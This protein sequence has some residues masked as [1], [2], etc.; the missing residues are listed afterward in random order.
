MTAICGQTRNN[1]S[2]VR[3]LK[4][5]QT[6]KVGRKSPHKPAA[7]APRGGRGRALGPGS[8]AGPPAHRAK[9][10]PRSPA[11]PAASDPS[12]TS[13]PAPQHPFDAIAP[14]E[15]PMLLKSLVV[16]TF[17]AAHGLPASHHPPDHHE[18]IAH[19]ALDAELDSLSQELLLL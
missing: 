12:Q 7:G 8:L 17:L 9:F 2:Q 10:A 11:P 4:L 5:V 19:R 14:N 16:L 6:N 3:Q 18:H 13:P 15:T 1:P